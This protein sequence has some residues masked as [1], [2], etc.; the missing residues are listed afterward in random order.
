[1]RPEVVLCIEACHRFADSCDRAADA[2]LKQK[3]RSLGAF[4]R[5][6]LDCADLCRFA[7]RMLTRESAIMGQIA[8]ACAGACDVCIQEP[9]GLEA[10]EIAECLRLAAR[11][12]HEC[13]RVAALQHP[14]GA[15]EP[16]ETAA[17]KRG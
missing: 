6:A 2:C 10:A 12:A 1:M 8:Q 3:P 13:R 17:V 9:A 4:W 14:Y 5:T 15:G 7:A 16:I 11:C